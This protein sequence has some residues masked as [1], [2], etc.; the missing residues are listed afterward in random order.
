[1][2]INGIGNMLR[3]VSKSSIVYKLQII[4]P[5]LNKNYFFLNL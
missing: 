3:N 2:L 5:M 1:M 4:M